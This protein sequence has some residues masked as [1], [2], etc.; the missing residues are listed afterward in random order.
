MM[1]KVV[2]LFLVVILALGILGKLH[3]LLPRKSHAKCQECGR[4]KIGK[5]PCDCGKTG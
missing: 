2:T 5:G 4:P 3:W 1:V